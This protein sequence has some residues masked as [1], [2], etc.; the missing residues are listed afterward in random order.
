MTKP[1]SYC[2]SVGALVEPAEIR[3]ADVLRG[4]SLEGTPSAFGLETTLPD[5][6]RCVTV[7]GED[8]LRQVLR[9]DSLVGAK[10]VALSAAAVGFTHVRA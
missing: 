5:A 2:W 7:A 1:D 8:R 6:N 4:A 9:G 3:G 10:E